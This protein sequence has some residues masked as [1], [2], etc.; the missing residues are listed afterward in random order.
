MTV[1]D[2]VGPYKVVSLIGKGGMGEVYL[3]V[4]PKSSRRIAVKVLPNHFVGDKK[5]GQYLEREV[6]VAQKLKHP[7]VIDIYGLHRQNGNGYLI[8]EYMDGGNL[9]QYIDNRNLSVYEAINLIL[10]ICDGL[11]YIHNHRFENGRFH[12]IVH[13]DI[14][15]ENILLSKYGQVKVA[16]FGLSL[17]DQLWSLR[18]P[19]SRAG[20]PLYMSPEQIRGKSL[21]VRTDIYSLGLVIYELLAGQLP[22]KAT[23]TQTYMKM[24]ISK[25]VKPVPPSYVNKMLPRKLDEITMRSLEKNPAE[26]YQTVAEMILE[27][28]RLPPVLKQL[29]F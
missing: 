14:K 12:S 13:R 22:F 11:H 2:K 9:R 18:S 16:D 4:D 6:K 1:K 23:D 24:T 25:N 20:T 3:A 7:N 28:H 17:S 15:P 26:R 21:D 10:K 5:R 8:M 27:L 29:S 19:R